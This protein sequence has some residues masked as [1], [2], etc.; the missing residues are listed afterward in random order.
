MPW[1][2]GY[3]VLLRWSLSQIKQPQ[4]PKNRDFPGSSKFR[5]N[6]DCALGML[7]FNE[8]R[9]RSVLSIGWETAGFLWLPPT[10]A[11]EGGDGKSIPFTK[12]HWSHFLSTVLSFLSDRWFSVCSVALVS[13]PSSKKVDVCCFAYIFTGFLWESLFTEVLPLS[14][15]KLISR[16][17]HS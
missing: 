1:E 3:F 16:Q 6:I 14:F 5:Q 11:G 8:L 12:Y 13:F 15:W 4:L 9:K 17:A 7:L 2:Q 10:W